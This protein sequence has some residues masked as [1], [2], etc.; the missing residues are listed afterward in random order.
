MVDW[1]DDT[2]KLSGGSH[3]FSD[4]NKL[5]NIENFS[6][7]TT[8]ST[9]DFTGQL[10]ALTLTGGSAVDNI[11][12]GNAADIISGAAND[13]ILVGG[14]GD[15]IISGGDGADTITGGANNDYLQVVLVMILLT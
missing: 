5:K 13:D 4:N 6:L 7:S 9:V 12:G 8:T 14:I 1:R 10:E 11:T 15:D 2:L 3:T